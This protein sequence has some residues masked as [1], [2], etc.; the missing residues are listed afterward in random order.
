[1]HDDLSIHAARTAERCVECMG[2]IGC[3]HHEQTHTK[4][5]GDKLGVTSRIVIVIIVIAFIVGY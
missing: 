5:R 2:P 4:Q 1:M 3:A